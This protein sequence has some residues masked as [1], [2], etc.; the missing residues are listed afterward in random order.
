MRRPNKEREMK[1]KTRKPIIYAEE[2]SETDWAL[3]LCI[4]LAAKNAKKA[5][6]VLD[7]Y[8]AAKA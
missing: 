6:N 5:H 2:T 3:L 7:A 1:N 4:L 8:F